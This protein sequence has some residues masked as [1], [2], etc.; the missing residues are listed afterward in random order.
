ML[1]DSMIQLSYRLNSTPEQYRMTPTC[2]VRWVLQNYRQLQ[3]F[4]YF[5]D[6]LHDYVTNDTTCV[7]K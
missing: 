5:W 7:P 1:L 3:I 4:P 6:I 2:P